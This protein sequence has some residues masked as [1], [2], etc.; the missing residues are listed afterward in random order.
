[1]EIEILV[2]GEGLVDVES[3]RVPAG[4][5]ARE[6]VAIVAGKG[7]FAVEEA[8]LFAE[9]GDEPVDLTVIIDERFVG[10]VHHV[11]RARR[12]EVV[13]FYKEKDHERQFSPSARVQRVLD[14][15][16]GP[17]GFKIDPAIAPEMEL[18]LH[19]QTKALPKSA[20]IGRFVH[21]GVH[22][23]ELDLIRGVVPNGASDEE[24]G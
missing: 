20:H 5:A 1:M 9:D 24:P 13:V 17:E 23:L 16:V 15:A 21:H 7:G 11:H 3:I 8:L 19:D 2:E 14:W 4:T 22:R 6:I 18:A 12:V 10:K